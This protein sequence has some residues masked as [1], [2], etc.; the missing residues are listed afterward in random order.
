M[1]TS[2]TLLLISVDY[3]LFFGQS[4]G[5]SENCLIKPTEALVEILD[6]HQ[7]KLS[8][9][10]DAGYLIKL[11]QYRTEHP[12]LADEYLK[13][14]NQLLNLSKRGHDIQ[15]HIHPHWHDSTYDNAD[16]WKM[17][18]HRYRLQDFSDKDIENIVKSYRDILLECTTSDIFAY[19]AGGWCL[20]PFAKIATHLKNNDIWLDSTVFKG[21]YSSDE[22]RAFDFRNHPESA[23]WHFDTDPLVSNPQGDFLEI[24]ISSMKTSPFFYWKLAAT[25]LLNKGMFQHFGDGKAML[26]NKQYYRDRLVKGS[27]GPVMIDGV[28]ASQLDQALNEH[29]KNN[30]KNAV[31]NV[32]GHPK[33]IS[34]YSLK[35][36]DAFLEKQNHLKS[37]TYQ[38]FLSH[39]TEQ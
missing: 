10:V 25:K 26:A 7:V 35:K 9:F 37:I 20:Q 39:R 2:K 17:D 6:K 31:F 16:G 34:E 4:T 38:H 36:L 8:L 30:P 22:L 33:S 28:K 19:R 18:T 32:M 23:T 5:S 15:L 21:G 1:D 27:F 14:K 12:H 13:I 3:E 29:K 11:N 24:P